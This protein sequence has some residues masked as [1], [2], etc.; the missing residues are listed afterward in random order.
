MADATEIWKP[1]FNP[2][3]IAVVVALAAFMEVLDT[4]IANVALPHHG[5][6]PGREQRRKHV[7]AHFLSG[8]QRHRSSHQRMAGEP[9]R[10]QALFPAVHFAVHR[11]LAAVRHRAQPGDADSVPRDSGRGRRRTCSPWRRPFWPTRSRRRNAAWRSRST[12]SPRSW[13]PPSARRSAAGSPTTIPGAGSSI[14][15][16]RSESLTLFLVL[17]MVEDPPYL[18]RNRN[19]GVRVD[20]IGIALL[21]LG[22]GALQI[23]LDK[24]QE[25][26]WFGSHFIVTLAVIC[27]GLPDFAG[28]LGVASRRR[29]SSTCACS[30]ASTS[31]WRT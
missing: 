14:S 15:I 8:V 20:Y 25:D 21:A 2:W 16:C 28:V 11:Q 9:V 17:R 19:A 26:D 18:A 27:G 30:R 5:R 3:L 24:G 29:P 13:R 22:V 1:K 23:L 6:R 7:G 12:E 4:S 31:P 10:A